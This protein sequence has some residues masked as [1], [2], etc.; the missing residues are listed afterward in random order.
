M[1]I[2]IFLF[3]LLA[4]FSMSGAA[5]A[6]IYQLDAT[7]TD[8]SRRGNFFITYNDMNDDGLFS[9]SEL[10][11]FSGIE[12]PFGADSAIFDSDDLIYVP[13]IAGLAIGTIGEDFWQFFNGAITVSISEGGWNYSVSAV[14][15]VPVPA[16][17]PL[18]GT[19]LAVLGLLGWRRKRKVSALA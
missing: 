17:L 13:D 19:G 4:S 1:K 3:V 8:L 5:N 6:M 15:S 18:F 12:I 14:P 10:V 11:A 9:H 16:A 2:K 7:S